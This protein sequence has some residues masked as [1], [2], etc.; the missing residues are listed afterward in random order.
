MGLRYLKL[1]GLRLCFRYITDTSVGD[2]GLEAKVQHPEGDPE[3][4]ALLALPQGDVEDL[5]T[6]QLHSP[7]HRYGW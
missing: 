4:E 5:Q 6:F 2:G 7:N 1:I 3:I